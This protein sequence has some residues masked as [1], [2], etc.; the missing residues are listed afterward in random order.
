VP[1]CLIIALANLLQ[2]PK[3][4]PS[5]TTPALFA[6]RR[7]TSIFPRYAFHT[8]ACHCNCY[9]PHSSCHRTSAYTCP[10]SA[11]HV[12]A[13]GLHVFNDSEV[14]AAV[15][16]GHRE[17]PQAIG[18]TLL[19]VQTALLSGMVCTTYGQSGYTVV[20]YTPIKWIEYRAAMAQRELRPFTFAD[21]TPGMKEPILRVVALPSRADHISGR[22]LSMSS[23]VSRVVL[24][25]KTKRTIIQPLTNKNGIVESNS[26]LRSINYTSASASFSLTDADQ[27]RGEDDK[28]EF[29]VVVV[30]SNQNK[31]FKVKT[32]MFKALF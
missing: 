16:K 3:P 20:I 11:S 31:Y 27:I 21:L 23:S 17:R 12:T 18:L 6:T 7:H 22:G 9:T 1:E 14:A 24:A 8:Y 26:T 28:G 10:P 15:E 4:T 13:S 19:D 5:P 30:G 2:T 29:F 32:R 25:D